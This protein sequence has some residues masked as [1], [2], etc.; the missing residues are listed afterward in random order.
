MKSG[1]VESGARTRCSNSN[2]LK[3]D[4]KSN[5]SNSKAATVSGSK[6]VAAVANQA[7][8]HRDA[9]VVLST[10]IAFKR[11]NFSVRMPVDQTDLEGKIADALN[12]VLEISQKTVSEF[13]RISRAVGKYGKITQRASIGS[14]TGA[15]ADCVESVNSLIGDRVQPSTEVAR[16]IGAVAKGDL[17][18]NMSLEVDGRP[19]RGE[20]LHTA[21]V[22][23]TMVQK[24]NS[25]T[26]EVTR[27]AREVGTEGKLGGQ[28]DVPG[29]GGTWKDLT[30]SVK[31]RRLHRS[32]GC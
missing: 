6:P 10:L 18:Q 13:E 4:A 27:V 31:P 2:N 22:V 21:R 1:T 3:I 24:L 5:G 25:F 26:S 14:V 23:N 16:V 12:D 9:N 32:R 28:A 17:S 8:A 19:L 20:F 7:K 15:W 11:G 30:D 29:V